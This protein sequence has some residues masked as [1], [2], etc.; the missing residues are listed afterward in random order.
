MS[1]PLSASNKAGTCAAILVMSPVILC[2]PAAS[3]LPVETNVIPVH[4]GMTVPP[5]H[6]RHHISHVGEQFVHHRSLVPLLVS[7]SLH[8]HGLGLCFTLLPNNR[9][10]RLT[11]CANCRRATF[12]LCCETRL[13]R[14]GQVFYPLPLNLGFFRA[15][16]AINSFSWR[17]ISA[18]CTL[19]WPSF[20][21]CCTFTCSNV[22]CCCITFVC[23]S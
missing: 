12:R 14:V 4:L 9:R 19:I 3:S 17:R 2:T 22:T 7:F 10:L 23:S 15:L 21:T 5:W 11:L 18:S 8:I 16:V 1:I 20:S 13:F 6:V